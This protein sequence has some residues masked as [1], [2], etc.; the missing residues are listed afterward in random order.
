MARLS[1]NQLAK[2][3]VSS[4]TAKIGI[5]AEAKQEGNAKSIR[6]KDAREAV[7]GY[8]T[9]PNRDRRIIDAAINRFD[10]MSRDSTLT[11]FKRSDAQ[12]SADALRAFE[13]LKNQL[14]GFEYF[15]APQ[16]QPKLEIA[17]VEISTRLDLLIR[18]EYR[19]E[20]QVGGVIFRWTQADDETEAAIAK[21]RDMGT[22]AATLVH[23]HVGQHFAHSMAP[24]YPICLSVDVQFGDVIAAPKT[25]SQRAK[26]MEN[27]CRFI[28]AI[29]DDI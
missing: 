22:Y 6:Y 28:S 18:R 19:E 12:S 5:I 11:T 21:R 17:G 2:Y 9:S 23:M 7:K 27:A 16:R 4:E 29:W 8:L 14:G 15:A 1:A 25:F 20:K 13:T 10:Q 3:M 24:A 26:N